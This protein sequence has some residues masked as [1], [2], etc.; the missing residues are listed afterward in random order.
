MTAH[1]TQ[2]DLRPTK[3]S[4]H[5]EQNIDRILSAVRLHLHMD[6]AFVTEFLEPNRIFRNVDCG[7]RY[8]PFS[9]GDVIPLASGYCK[10][11]VSGALP[12]LIPDTH[13]LELSRSLPET[14]SIPIGAHLSVPIK[15]EDGRTFG[16]FCCFSHKPKP[17]L[18][19]RDLDLLRTFGNILAAD[20]TADVKADTERRAS[21]ATINGA[22][23]KGE[24]QIV[25]QP[26]RQLR[27]RS[28]IGVEALARFLAEPYRTPDQWFAEAH[29]LGIGPE[30]ELAAMTAA[31]RACAD[32]PVPRSVS[33]NVSPQTLMSTSLADALAG[34]DPSRIV[35]EITE[36]VPI[37]DYAP[38]IKAL[39]PLR[40]SGIRI[41]IDDAGA[42][43]SSMR[44][45][46]EMRPDIIKFDISLTRNVDCD[47]VRKAMAAAL[48][49]F[50]RRSETV[51]VAEGIETE[52]EFET[53]R[54]LGFQNGQG[55]LLGRPVQL[56]DLL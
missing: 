33:I 22:L 27:D 7:H 51:L 38:I 45:I 42:G 48:G 14:A 30:L 55:Y 9:P 47:P 5:I 43:Y 25:F 11:V 15:V 40:A 8:S 39:G 6:V 46:L 32:L 29:E 37:A 28:L 34:F 19:Q 13:E 18:N 4:P 52:G 36:H 56:R 12:E 3:I 35:I 2:W 20:I 31:I 26:I 44:H 53:L 50:A 21:I 49:E 16:T 1:A 10:Y 23:A 17:E 41:A 54:E 24:P